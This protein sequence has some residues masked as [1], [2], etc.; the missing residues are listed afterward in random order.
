MNKIG[1]L[2]KTNTTDKENST[3]AITTSTTSTLSTASSISSTSTTKQETKNST[4]EEAFGSISLKSTNLTISNPTEN[5]IRP[6][7]TDQTG[8][9]TVMSE[10]TDEIQEKKAV[11]HS[12]LKNCPWI[13]WFG[14]GFGFIVVCC[15]F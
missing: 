7:D 12:E 6:N 10:I 14:I 9:T 5:A 8:N 2:K 1:D 13:T 4:S 15:E 3:I 11:E